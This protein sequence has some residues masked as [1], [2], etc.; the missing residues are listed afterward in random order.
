MACGRNFPRLLARTANG[1]ESNPAVDCRA[2]VYPV[3]LKQAFDLRKSWLLSFEF[4]PPN[5]DGGSHQIFFWGDGRGG[6]DPLF[7]RIDGTN[8]AAACTD[9]A[10]QRSQW[11]ETHVA[12]NVVGQWVNLKYVHDT[13]AGEMQLYINHRL[14]G[15]DSMTLTPNTDRPMPLYIGGTDATGQRYFGQ[16]RNVWLGNIP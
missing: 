16:V 14:V 3:K 13:I 12:P 5:L 8:I 15:R 7:V 9:C 11:L 10:N 1:F 6:Q 4:M 2:T